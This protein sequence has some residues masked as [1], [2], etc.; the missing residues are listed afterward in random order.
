M[1]VK[2]W[3]RYHLAQL[4]R[5]ISMKHN[6]SRPKSRKWVTNPLKKLGSEIIRKP[7]FCSNNLLFLFGSPALRWDHYAP[8]AS[9]HSVLL[10]FTKIFSNERISVVSQTPQLFKI[11]FRFSFLPFRFSF[12][13]KFSYLNVILTKVFVVLELNKYVII[14]FYS[15]IT[16][17]KSKII[18]A[19]LSF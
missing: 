19:V 11:N 13:R 12:L 10:S 1:I 4:F 17:F 5:A 15:Y 2:V 16:F 6:K 3:G 14:L 8:H 7:H 9:S 18:F